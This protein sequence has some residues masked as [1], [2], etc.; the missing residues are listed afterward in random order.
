MNQFKNP[1]N[2]L[3]CVLRSYAMV[4]L[5]PYVKWYTDKRHRIQEDLIRQ[6]RLQDPFVPIISGSIKKHTEINLR[7][8]VD[9]ICPFPFDHPAASSL[10]ELHNA[11]LM[12]FQTYRHKDHQLLP[13][14]QQNSSIGLRFTKGSLELAMDIVPGKEIGNGTYQKGSEY[15]HI[16]DRNS[17]THVQ[18]NIVKQVEAIRG[19]P[20]TARKFIRLLKVWKTQFSIPVKSIVLELLVI[21]AFQSRHPKGNLWEQFQTVLESMIYELRRPDF[22]LKDPGYSKNDLAKTMTSWDRKRFLNGLEEILA[23]C[24]DRP[25]KITLYFTPNHNY[26]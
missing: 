7:F 5:D 3:Q 22:K 9:L 12:F 23:H 13:P 11:V 20:D 14:R 25:E 17:R 2:H 24:G 4:H 16:L 19:C 26:L 10:S 6:F 15:L 21:R 1:S 8:D 18:T